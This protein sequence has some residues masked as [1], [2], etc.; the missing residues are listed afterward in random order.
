M[1]ANARFEQAMTNAGYTLIQ[2]HSSAFWQHLNGYRIGYDYAF[3]F[4]EFTRGFLV[5]APW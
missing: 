2:G 3:S 1:T 4:W 5:V